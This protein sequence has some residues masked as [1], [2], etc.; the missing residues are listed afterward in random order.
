MPELMTNPPF[1]VSIFSR[2]WQRSC[3]FYC[4]FP[5][6]VIKFP[7]SGH[8]FIVQNKFCLSAPSFGEPWS[9]LMGVLLSCHMFEMTWGLLRV[10]IQGELLVMDSDTSCQ[11]KIGK[12]G[13]TEECNTHS[14]SVNKVVLGRNLDQNEWQLNK[15][16]NNNYCIS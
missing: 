7:V 13:P 1:A 4:C 11:E 3:H 10:D 2:Q 9:C 12:L 14:N 15:Q 6:E 8:F 16:I 5:A